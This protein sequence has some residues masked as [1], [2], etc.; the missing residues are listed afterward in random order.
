MT[1]GRDAE[2]TPALTG[3]WHKVGTTPCAEKYPAVIT[4]TGGTYRGARGSEQGMVWWDAGIHRLEG[5]R[6]LVLSTAT[7]E[8]VAYDIDVRGDEFTITDPEGCRFAYRRAPAA[9]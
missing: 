1:S 9:P 6:K 4:F 3:T 7:D 5:P 2:Q 8:L